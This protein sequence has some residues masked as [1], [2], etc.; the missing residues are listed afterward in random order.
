MRSFKNLDDFLQL[1]EKELERIGQKPFALSYPDILAVLGDPRMT[2]FV[3]EACRVF[4]LTLEWPPLTDA[5]RLEVCVRLDAAR[6][7]CASCRQS[8][9][10][11]EGYDVTLLKEL[12]IKYYKEEGRDYWKADRF[13]QDRKRLPPEAN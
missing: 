10:P 8:A 13:L 7:W 12:L 9:Y 6:E 1:F 3:D 2:E 11:G 5:Q 4:C